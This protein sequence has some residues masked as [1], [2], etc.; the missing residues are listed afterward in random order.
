MI[1]ARM[2]MIQARTNSSNL[3]KQLQIQGEPAQY[4]RKN[5]PID[6]N[7]Q[8]SALRI[9]KAFPN[10]DC[11]KRLHTEQNIHGIGTSFGGPLSQGYV[12]Y[13][14]VVR[15]GSQSVW[16]RMFATIWGMILINAFLAFTFFEPARACSSYTSSDFLLKLLNQQL[17]RGNVSQNPSNLQ[18]STHP[19]S[20]VYPSCLRDSIK[21][22][23]TDCLYRRRKRRHSKAWQLAAR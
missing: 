5:R 2:Y 9:H 15:Q 13:R 21:I 14:S 8:S 23:D 20:S 16:H 1:Q 4:A 17:S 7:F 12:S 18:Q 19:T 11:N 10:R 22:D 3:E 6:E